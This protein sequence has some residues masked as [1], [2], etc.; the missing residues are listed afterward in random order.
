MSD[1][2]I[3]IISFD[4]G[5]TLFWEPACE[6]HNAEPVM[7]QQFNELIKEAEKLG[8]EIPTRD[9]LYELY[10]NIGKRIWNI[11]LE[12]E[13][14]HKYI[15]LRFFFELGVSIKLDDLEHLYWFFIDTIAKRFTIPRRHRQL[16]EYL[17]GMGYYIVLTTSTGAHDLP[18]RILQYT[19]VKDYFKQVFSTQLVGLLKTDPR[20]YMEIADTLNINP[21]RIVH[22]GDSLT[23][24]ILPAK[25]AGYRTILFDWRTKCRPSDTDACVTD[26]WDILDY[27]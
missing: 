13:L 7:R 4:M 3:K 8:Y 26:L 6:K 27:L 18:L 5:C 16:L 17:S 11:S 24:D 20:F 12:R 1:L 2:L 14:W 9:N 15:L 25:K 21:N 22:I 19:G 10:F 23:H